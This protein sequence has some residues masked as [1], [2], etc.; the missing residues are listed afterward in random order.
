[1]SVGTLHTKVVL[2]EP[3]KIHCGNRDPV[4][5][6]VNITYSPG[7][8][9]AGAELFGHLS[10]F[11]TLHGRAKTK[12]WKSNGQSTSIYRGRA[13]LFSRRVLVYDDSFRAQ[14]RDAAILPFSLTFPEFTDATAVDEFIDQD[15]KYICHRNQP[16]PPS[17]QNSYHGFAHRY[18]A[19][20]EYRVGVDVAMPQIQVHVNKP[21][22]YLEPVVHYERPKTTQMANS[23]PHDWR[24]YISVRN[25]LLL[26]ESDRP[27]GFKEKTKALFGAT[28]FPAYAFDWVCFVPQDVYLGQPACFEVHIKPRER[29]CTATLVPEIRLKN[30]RVEIKAHTQV[31]ARRSIFRCPESEGNYTVHA[32]V[33]VID[34]NDPFSKANDNTKFINTE[35]LGSEKIGTLP[36]SFATY[37]I[38]QAYALKI[39]FAF[40]ITDKVKHIDRENRVMV[41]PPLETGG[42]SAPT[43]AGPSSQVSGGE[44]K[45][46]KLP[47]YEFL[48]P[49]EETPKKP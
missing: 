5:G 44:T 31:R 45:E 37:N 13:P 1:M 16:L 3:G 33:G 12:I 41:H 48:P 38:S 11:V 4:R 28:N 15:S 10:V 29:E 25:E 40:E 24:G 20:V 6:H 18:E 30:F 39:S 36:S 22:K 43:A 2:D 19:F 35:A 47:P 17:F 7:Q 46:S 42:L 8:G 23:R 9:N 32:T 21:T 26:P 27:S 49:Y 14:P 34:N